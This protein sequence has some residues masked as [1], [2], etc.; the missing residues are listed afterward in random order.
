MLL[1]I[2]LYIMLAYLML[3]AALFHA[4]CLHSAFLPFA[5]SNAFCSHALSCIID[6]LFQ[7]L[8]CIMHS[9]VNPV[10]FLNLCSHRFSL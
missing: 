5:L 2:M 4:V 3:F 9:A 10:V 1:H 8:F 7:I 6:S